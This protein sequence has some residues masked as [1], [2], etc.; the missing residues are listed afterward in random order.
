MKEHTNK[1]VETSERIVIDYA[2]LSGRESANRGEFRKCVTE[3]LQSFLLTSLF[4][5]DE[6][7]RKR[8][9]EAIGDH[10]WKFVKGYCD[11]CD[12]MEHSGE[13]HQCEVADMFKSRLRTLLLNN[14]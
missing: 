11:T 8:I 4:E 2:N 13:C 12:Y 1:V 9:E 5:R 7:W 3:H 10:K 6:L 14:K